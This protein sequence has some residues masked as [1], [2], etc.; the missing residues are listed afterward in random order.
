MDCLT[1]MAP[2]FGMFTVK[3]NLSRPFLVLLSC[4]LMLFSTLTN[5]QEGVDH[6]AH[7]AQDADKEPTS[8]TSESPTSE[9]ADPMVEMMRGMHGPPPKDIYPRLLSLDP[10]DPEEMDAIHA[11]AS[12]RIEEGVREMS[13]TIAALKDA[14]V[15]DDLS[16][17]TALTRELEAATAK[18]RAGAAVSAATSSPIQA[19]EAAINWFRQEMNLPAPVGPNRLYWG[20]SPLH[21]LV[22][23]TLLL[24][25]SYAF[26]SYVGRVRRASALLETLRS[27]QSGV[28]SD[29]FRG[30]LAHPREAPG[31]QNPT[32]PISKR[33]HW[34]GD[35][36]VIGVYEET[37]NVRTFRLALADQ[38]PLPFAYEPGQFCTVTAPA[39]EDGTDVSRSYTIASSPTDRDA[40]ELTIKREAEGQMSRYL[41]DTIDVNSELRIKAPLGRFYFNGEQSER[42]ALVAGGVGVT[43][44]MSAL[45]YLA[46]HCWQGRIAFLYFA[47]SERDIIFHDELAQLARRMPNLNLNI[48]LSEPADPSWD[49]RKGM[50]TVDGVKEAVPDI[51]SFRVH[52]CGPQPMMDAT[53]RVMGEL[54]VAPDAFKMES[55]GDAANAPPGARPAP[56]EGEDTYPIAFARTNAATEISSG[57]TVL[58]AADLVKAPIDRSC[59]SGTCGACIVKLLQGEVQM[60][61]DDALEADEIAEGYILA[62]Q[63]RPQS[64][65]T[66]DA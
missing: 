9:A 47:K 4:L 28:E 1:K 60:D 36:K 15:A 50:V 30:V 35:V 58:E 20:L 49:G 18:F 24:L 25:S 33:E 46:A 17:I 5:A 38:S 16:K 21:L 23:A 29:W 19:R 63:A 40:F 53:K 48:W 41:H 62:C 37:H 13:R 65:L 44:M 54:S 56:Q 61:V 32:T 31:E 3:K 59:L 34:I 11:D 27:P 10:S 2:D 12:R 45:R 43:P 66:V 22:M 51:A 6:E 64:K 42:I 26:F 8:E 52:V 55:F 14:F 7:H 39:G 57:Q